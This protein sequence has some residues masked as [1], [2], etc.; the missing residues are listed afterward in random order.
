M[1]KSLKIIIKDLKNGVE[2]DS[3]SCGEFSLNFWA[4]NLYSAKYRLPTQRT[5]HLYVNRDGST[6]EFEIKEVIICDNE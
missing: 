4:G 1:K 3:S 5:S 6:A 2:I